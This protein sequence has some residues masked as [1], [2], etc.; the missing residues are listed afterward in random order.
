MKENPV[1]LWLLTHAS[2]GKQDARTAAT[3]RITANF[4]GR[5]SLFFIRHTAI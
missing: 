3:K 1:V 4:P 5:D 2:R